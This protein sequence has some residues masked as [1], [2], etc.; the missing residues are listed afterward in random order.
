MTQAEIA[1]LVDEGIKLTAII[2]RNEGRLSEI[3]ARLRALAGNKANTFT[4]AT[5]TAQISVVPGHVQAVSEKVIAA[6]GMER[7]EKKGLL[8]KTADSVKVQ[9]IKAKPAKIAKAA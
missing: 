1:T 5:G 7:L 2:K 8:S 4:G 6:Y 3:K 9:L